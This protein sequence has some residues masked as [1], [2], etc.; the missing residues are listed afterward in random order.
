MNQDL[1]EFVGDALEEFEFRS[2]TQ[3]SVEGADWC[4]IVEWGS[5]ESEIGPTYKFYVFSPQEYDYTII[6]CRI[7]IEPSH[8]DLINDLNDKGI[9]FL[10]TDVHKIVA[11][12]PYETYPS[13]EEGEVCMIE[14]A[15][16]YVI[17]SYIF[18]DDMS[19]TKI[20][21]RIMS[22]KNLVDSFWSILPD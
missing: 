7:D 18:G 1:K 17:R 5:S 6:E 22:T 3:T 13:D 10:K 19:K 4:Y 11:G 16:T 8:R 15:D 12:K 14:F 9:E 20:I 21:D 2:V